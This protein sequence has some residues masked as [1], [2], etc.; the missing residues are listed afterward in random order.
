MV[1]N[2]FCLYSVH[3]EN[4]DWTCFEQSADLDIKSFFGFEGTAEK[5]SAN[6]ESF[7]RKC[8]TDVVVG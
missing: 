7:A 5:V 3:P 1:I 4:P 6:A 2:E 8:I